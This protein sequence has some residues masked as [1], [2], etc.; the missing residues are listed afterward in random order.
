MSV[1]TMPRITRVSDPARSI[2]FEAF[3][4]TA[5]LSVPAGLDATGI[6]EVLP[7]T[8]VPGDPERVE[9]RFE[10]RDD[11]VARVRA[12]AEIRA[13]VALH[14]P[15][16]VFVHA[17]VVVHE[18]RA[19]VLPGRSLSGK[20]TLVAALLRA[21]AAY[22]SDE[23]AAVDSDGLVHPYAKP[24]SIRRPHSF[25]Q[26][27]T[28]P[29]ELDAATVEGPV[30]AGLVAITVHVPGAVWDPERRDGG[31]GALALVENTVPA[32]HRPAQVLAAVSRVVS[33]AEV[34]EGPR[35]EAEATAEA[36]LAGAAA[37]RA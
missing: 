4:V 19:I 33:D 35:G 27:E 37:V 26:T 10:L 16:H 28:A 36:L 14:A 11:S 20:T 7:P 8:W 2:V 13:H 15:D 5:E 32:R 30:R 6:E 34:L 3:G 12:E 22:A 31:R 17:G 23:F 9:E 18:G 24:L 29:E 1:G 25:E 21:G